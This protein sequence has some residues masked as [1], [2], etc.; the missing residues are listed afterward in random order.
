MYVHAL[1]RQLSLAA[2]VKDDK[3]RERLRYLENGRTPQ[4]ASN[5]LTRNSRR[6]MTN[7]F[8]TGSLENALLF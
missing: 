4:S 6:Y 7:I 2:G 3:N 1:K 8:I 5:N